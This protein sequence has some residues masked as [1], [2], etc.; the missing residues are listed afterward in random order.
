MS[1][2]FH[3][4]G[5]DDDGDGNGNNSSNNAFFAC[6]KFYSTLVEW[7]YVLFQPNVKF[8]WV[9]QMALQMRIL[10]HLLLFKC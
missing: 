1:A 6:Q 8:L 10:T 2:L 7:Q 4:D 5:D 3:N 9:L